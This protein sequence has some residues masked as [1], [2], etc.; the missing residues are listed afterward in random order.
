MKALNRRSFL[1]TSIAATAALS[2]GAGPAR[3]EEARLRMSWWGSQDRA[4]R[5]LGVAELYKQKAPGVTIVGEA[6]SGD[7]YWTKLATQMAGRNVSDIFQLEPSTVSDYS[8]RGATMALD[9]FIPKPL[10][11]EDFG[12][13][14]LDLCKVD[15]K[16]QGIG[17]GLNSFSMFYDTAVFAKAGLP[18]PTPDTTWAQFADLSVE[19]TKAVGKDQFWGA[20]Y[21]ARYGYIIDV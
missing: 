5:T 7:A 14:M 21:G 19:L 15:G 12:T 9:Q 13:K 8:K 2:L 18:V 16:I 4:K 10:G 3:A 17:L 11:V 6:V 20:P 1:Q